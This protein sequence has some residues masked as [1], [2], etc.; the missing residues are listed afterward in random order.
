MTASGIL[1]CTHASLQESVPRLEPHR[2]VQLYIISAR[3]PAPQR[4]LSDTPKFSGYGCWLLHDG[5]WLLAA[6]NTAGCWLLETPA[7]NTIDDRSA[8]DV[9]W[10]ADRAW[11]AC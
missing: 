9:R 10:G 2:A 3:R 11:P 4:P 8:S 1:C 7:E 5:C 6:G